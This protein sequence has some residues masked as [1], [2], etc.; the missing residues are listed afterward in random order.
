MENCIFVRQPSGE[1]KEV[2]YQTG[3]EY[4]LPINLVELPKLFGSDTIDS[5]N[6]NTVIPIIG[7]TSII[8]NV[9]GTWDQTLEIFGSVDGTNYFSLTAIKKDTN[10]VVPEITSNAAYVINCAAL[11]HVKIESI[12]YVSGTANL[13]WSMG[14]NTGVMEA[15]AAQGSFNEVIVR[16]PFNPN[17]KATVDSQGR[18]KVSIAAPDSYTVEM[19]Y[20]A[21]IG[22][23]V[24]DMWQSVGAYTIPAGYKLEAVRF[25][26]QADNSTSWARAV[27]GTDMAYFNLDTDV[28]TDVDNIVYPGFASSL[29]VEIFGDIQNDTTIT[30][31]YTNESNV[32]GRTATVILEDT[33][34][35]GYIYRVTLQTGDLGVR[36]VTNVTSS[37]PLAGGLIH[38][39]AYTQLFVEKM[40]ISGQM[41][42][43]WAPREAL[44]VQTGQQI[45]GQYRS[46]QT[47]AVD[48]L[49]EFSGSLVPI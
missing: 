21:L 25:N 31:T 6:D 4:N 8:L 41:Y 13:A 36:D 40:T 48:R 28:F 1:Y 37:V 14:M 5:L 34:V 47:S 24:K 35:T 7:Y 22:P 33:D 10:T 49:I 29:V 18:L 16:D 9:T 12:T 32:T 39:A 23:P 11:S 30:I 46:E 17:Y 44:S 3:L 38:V 26:C 43:Q 27:I 45:I 2:S 42:T 20:Q 15:L 19:R